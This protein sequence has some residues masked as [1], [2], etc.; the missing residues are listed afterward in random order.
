MPMLLKD[1]KSNLDPKLQNLLS[2]LDAGLGSVLR[3]NDPSARGQL[4]N[5]DSF[6]GN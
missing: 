2:E 1:S 3:K 5:E 6:G 4:A